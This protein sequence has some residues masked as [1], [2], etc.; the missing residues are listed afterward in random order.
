MN[1]WDLVDLSAPNIVGN[2]LV[3]TG[4]AMAG[5]VSKI[6]ILYKLVKSSNLWERRI[7]ILSTFSFI[8]NND[9]YHTLKISELL[10]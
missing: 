10:L 7:A 8:R 9:F 3:E 6:D 2:Y 4:P 1:N 5:P